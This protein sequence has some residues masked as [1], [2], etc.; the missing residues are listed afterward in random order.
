MAVERFA[1]LLIDANLR[2]QP[3]ACGANGAPSSV[4]ESYRIQERVLRHLASERR[5]SAWKVSPPRPGAEPLASPVPPAR[6]FASPAR[7]CAGNRIVL[8]V[9][10]E[11]AFRFGSSPRTDSDSAQ[12]A[13]AVS[14]AVVLI[15]LCETRFSDWNGASAL[16]RLADFQSNGAFVVGTGEQSWQSIDFASQ[17]AM[18]MVDGSVAARASGSHR[19]GDPFALVAWA[20]AHCARR[21][22]PLAAG[23]IV[24]T[25]TWTGMTRIAPGEEVVASFPGIGEA[26]L[27]LDR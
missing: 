5:A 11:I 7:I 3:F 2:A 13:E 16:S 24:T 23:D 17:E 12:V 26:R 21:G 6:V 20:V 22:M 9:E 27:R 18:L 10:A 1:Q 15:E 19:G 25:G 4:E 8:G 14:E